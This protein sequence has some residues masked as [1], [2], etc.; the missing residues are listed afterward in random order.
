MANQFLDNLSA[1]YYGRTSFFNQDVTVYSN[2]TGLQKALIVGQTTIHGNLFVIKNPNPLTGKPIIPNIVTDGNITS[3]LN[4]TAALT[5]N[6]GTSMNAPVFNGNLNGVASGNKVLAAFDI[7]HVKDENKRIRHICAEGPEAGIYVRGKLTDSD[8]IELPEYW[9]GLVDPDTIT[10]SLTQIG[11]SQDLIVD[12]IDGCKSIKIRS[13][14]GSNINC[15]YEVWVARWINPMD[16]SEELHVVYEG[17]SPEDYPGNKSSFL[18]GGWDYDKRN[19]K[20]S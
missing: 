18:V 1:R 5:V 3:A 15:F 9:D 10:V 20:W 7:Q 11:S 13:G 8:T 6:A 2:F 17:E 16:H 12:E 4:I 14:N 19:P